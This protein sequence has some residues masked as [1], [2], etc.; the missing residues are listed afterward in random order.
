MVEKLE[1]KIAKEFAKKCEDSLSNIFS[2]WGNNICY[3]DDNNYA[4]R[5][6]VFKA[7]HSWGT[8]YC[9]YT[10]HSRYEITDVLRECGATNIKI[11]Q[12]TWNY[13]YITFNI[14]KTV[15]KNLLNKKEN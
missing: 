11:K 3:Y 12:F 14:K 9:D 6:F 8:S 10:H 5:Q 4:E 13:A 7:S 2:I 15:Y 1:K